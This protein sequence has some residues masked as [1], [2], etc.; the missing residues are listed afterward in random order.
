VPASL[1]RPADDTPESATLRQLLYRLGVSEANRPDT[2]QAAILHVWSRVTGG[3]FDCSCAPTEYTDH[4][5]DIATY[6]DEADH[7]DNAQVRAFARAQLPTLH[8][9]L[10]L[11][12]ASLT[13]LSCASR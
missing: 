9:H 5:G 2:E 8:A 6:Q 3:A 7:G 12:G 4:E 1:N 13:G 10:S 11:A